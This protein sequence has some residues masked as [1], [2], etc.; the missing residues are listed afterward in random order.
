MKMLAIEEYSVMELTSLFFSLV[1]HLYNLPFEDENNMKQENYYFFT[2]NYYNP[3]LV[4]ISTFNKL[5]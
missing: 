3:E 4:I 5:N 2:L 1:V